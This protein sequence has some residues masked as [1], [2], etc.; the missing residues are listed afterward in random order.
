M[1]KQPKATIMNIVGLCNVLQADALRFQ[2]QFETDE[3]DLALAIELEDC[4]KMLSSEVRRYVK[5]IREE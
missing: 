1:P 3:E 2:G 5:Q 4:C